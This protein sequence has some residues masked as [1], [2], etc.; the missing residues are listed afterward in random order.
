[1]VYRRPMD[2]LGQ[3]PAKNKKGRPFGQPFFIENIE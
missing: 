3:P 2:L 1:M